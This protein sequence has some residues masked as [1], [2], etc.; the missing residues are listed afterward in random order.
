MSE[1]PGSIKGRKM[2]GKDVDL[3][4]G[5]HSSCWFLAPGHASKAD[6]PLSQYVFSSYAQHQ[7]QDK[8]PPAAGESGR[9]KAVR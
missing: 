4:R 8:P 2:A 1:L 9:D 3:L 6:F 7:M 5:S